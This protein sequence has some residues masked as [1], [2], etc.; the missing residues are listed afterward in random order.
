MRMST[1]VGALGVLTGVILLASG[2]SSIRAAGGDGC[3]VPGEPFCHSNACTVQYYTCAW[4]IQG[5]ICS[6]SGSNV[7]YKTLVSG[8]T[9]YDSW[10]ELTP[11]DCG[12]LKQCTACDNLTEPP[13]QPCHQSCCIGPGVIPN[14]S[15]TELQ[16]EPNGPQVCGT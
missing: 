7:T 16:A 10:R 13:N 1:R 14:S 3:G 6:G 5:V 12:P 2:L 11:K 9:G 4:P 8:P 15:K